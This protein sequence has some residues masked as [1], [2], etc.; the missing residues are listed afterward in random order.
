[1]ES[2]SAPGGVGLVRVRGDVSALLSGLG[3]AD[4]NVG[5]VGLRSLPVVGALVVARWGED[6][7]QL[8]PHG[9]VAQVAE[10]SRLLAAAGVSAW[11]R[12]PEPI[13]S[14]EV[15]RERLEA[16]LERVRSPLGVDLLLDQPRRWTEGWPNDPAVDR[17]LNR[18]M[19][20]PLVA[21]VGA[22]NVGKS[23]LVNALSGNATSI[24]A[25][26]PGTTR[27]HVG[28]SVDVD[29]LVIR[30]IDCPGIRET[31]DS[32]EGQIECRAIEASL[33]VASMADVVVVAV[34]PVQPALVPPGRLVL[35]ADRIMRV[36]LR[37]DVT[38]PQTPG[39]WAR[40][41]DCV[42]SVHQ[43]MGLE[44]FRVA[45]RERLLPAAAWH[46]RRSWKFWA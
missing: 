2:P 27:D 40:T 8:M 24:V 17:V 29:G 4:V 41:C 43:G 37:A 34:D 7:V 16:A 9:G 45:L 31:D 20:P 25:D 46:A 22:P 10:L 6:D 33:E 28:V 15:T 36:G 11:D 18:L 19:N 32:P 39:D 44:S 30:L 1:M 13:D 23:T 26:E 3:L 42:L 38:Q 14:D 5:G 21:I 12:K 35:P